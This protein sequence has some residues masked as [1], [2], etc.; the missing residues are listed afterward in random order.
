MGD[1]E[2]RLQAINAYSRRNIWF[3]QIDFQ[4]TPVGTPVRMLPFLPNVSMTVDF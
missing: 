3:N 4:N 2:L 1:Y